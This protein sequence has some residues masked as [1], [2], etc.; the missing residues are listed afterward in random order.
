MYSLTLPP[1]KA[2]NEDVI[3]LKMENKFTAP[4]RGGKRY[5]VAPIMV[6]AAL[7]LSEPIKLGRI[8]PYTQM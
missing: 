7:R 6:L 1:K 3:A 5:H 2:P 8:A 4:M